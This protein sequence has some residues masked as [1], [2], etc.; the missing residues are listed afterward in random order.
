MS[1]PLPDLKAKGRPGS[2]SGMPRWGKGSGAIAIVV[3]VLVGLM[4]TG[5]IGSGAHGPGRRLPPGGRPS[6]SAGQVVQQS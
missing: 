4:L 6:S 1:D 3:G 5:L 2:P